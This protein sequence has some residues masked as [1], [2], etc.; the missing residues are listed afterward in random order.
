MQDASGHPLPRDNQGL[1][2]QQVQLSR[3][4]W[5][6]EGAAGAI[7]SAGWRESVTVTWSPALAPD[8]AQAGYRESRV[9]DMP[10]LAVVLATH[11]PET[12]SYRQPATTPAGTAS[13]FGSKNDSAP[14]VT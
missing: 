13:S 10:D 6:R 1:W 7:S 4:H 9:P 2:P 12:R 8:P 5:R 11:R 14:A 3:G